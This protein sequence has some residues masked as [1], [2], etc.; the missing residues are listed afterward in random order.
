MIDALDAELREVGIGNRRRRR[1][2]AEF[3]DHLSCD[4]AAELGDPQAIAHQFA[5]ELGTQQTRAAATRGFLVLA[6]AGAVYAAAFSQIGT[7]G[8]L[9][10]IGG[11]GSTSELAHIG[12]T[13]G[14]AGALGTI[15][16]GILVVA[17]QVAFVAGALA[18]M[19]A[20]RHRHVRAV[21]AAESRLVLRRTI[22]GVL[23]GL[24]TMGALALAPKL[25]GDGTDRGVTVAAAIAAL[26]LVAVLGSMIPAIRTRSSEPGEVG[27]GAD[28]WGRFMPSSLSLHPWRL[29]ITTA[30]IV[31]FIVAAAGVVVSD[32][33]DGLLRGL[34]EAAAC[35]V[36]FGLLG[37][38]LGLRSPAAGPPTVS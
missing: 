24:I 33:Y 23:A 15:I 13:A 3:R 18:L 27:G 12:T 16:L 17:P 26:A 8:E 38:I 19:R 31:G 6:I 21:P 20:F 11:V 10:H 9:A 35:L 2:V 28:D 36:G 29:A 4:P 37:G 25:P 5:S 1:I 32:P 22:V 30:L 14:G 34:V 7:A